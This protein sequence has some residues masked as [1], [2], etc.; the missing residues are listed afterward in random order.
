MALLIVDRKVRVEF[1][2]LAGW[3]ATLTMV[4]HLN[5]YYLTAPRETYN[6]PW[7]YSKAG[8]AHLAELIIARKAHALAGNKVCRERPGLE[9]PGTPQP[10]IQSQLLAYDLV[11]EASGASF[12]AV[13]SGVAAGVSWGVS[14]A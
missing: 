2:G 13:V 5:A 8:L 6:I 11:S 7:H 12:G 14:V 9:K 4:E 3:S 10:D 1:T